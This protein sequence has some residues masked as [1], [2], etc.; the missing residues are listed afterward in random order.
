LR[1]T[2]T[3]YIL[4]LLMVSSMVLVIQHADARQLIDSEDF[5]GINGSH[6]DPV[7]WDVKIRD[8]DDDVQIW[9]NTLRTTIISGGTAYAIS[10]NEFDTA[11][12]TVLVDWMT[13]VDLGRSGEVRIVTHPPGVPFERWVHMFYDEYHGWSDQV[14][15]EGVRSFN[16]SMQTNMVP[17]TWY[18]WNLTINYDLV[19]MTVTEKE[20]GALIFRR[21]GLRM[22]PIEDTVSV[23]IGSYGITGQST[24]GFW[25]GY[26]V[27]ATGHYPNE[28]P[29]WGD[30]P[31]FNAI[32]EV[33]LTYDF[34]SDVSDPDGD[35]VDLAITST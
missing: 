17:K 13:T 6:P 29:V 8:P 2:T 32:E 9:N 10:L 22:D 7:N 20:T 1:K 19:N 35:L 4:A 5:T 16:Y 33:P 26:E 31:T 27:Y 23:W 34:S 21:T 18:T 24:A 15:Y 11:N 3:F 12:L 28:P 25:D 14:M 30:L